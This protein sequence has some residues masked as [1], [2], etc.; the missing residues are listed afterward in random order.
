[1]E[2]GEQAGA[3]VSARGHTEAVEPSALQRTY[4]RRVA[5][6]KATIPHLY[7]RADVDMGRCVEVSTGLRSELGE[8]APS[9]ADMVVRA[10]GLALREHP[11]LNAAYH[12]ARF[13]FHSRVNVAITVAAQDTLILPVIQDADQHEVTAIAARRAELAERARAGTITRP[14][15]SGATFTVASF[16]EHGVD[17]FAPAV[18]HGQG[19]MLAAGAVREAPLVRNGEVVPGH[20]MTLTLCCDQRLVQGDE[21]AAFL[22]HVRGVLEEPDQ[23]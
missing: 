11:R 18:I 15:L 8:R 21:G 10:A 23:L 17:E 6:S 14:E 7:L 4:A 12:D 19:A 22:R 2:G 1:M 20:V 5:E 3:P 9:Y 13:E 16:G